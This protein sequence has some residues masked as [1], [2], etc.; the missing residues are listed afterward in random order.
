MVTSAQERGGVIGMDTEAVT[1]PLAPPRWRSPKRAGALLLVTV[2]SAPACLLLGSLL[3][4]V[5]A[6]IVAL[7]FFF[8]LVIAPTACVDWAV[9]SSVHYGIVV[10]LWA[11]VSAAYACLTR[12][13]RLRSVLWLWPAVVVGV[14]IAAAA[15]LAWAQVPQQCSLP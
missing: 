9:P 7:G 6:P 1:G 5:G 14:T 15:L 8:W 13:W 11:A 10:L 2:L 3:G 4:P 12:N